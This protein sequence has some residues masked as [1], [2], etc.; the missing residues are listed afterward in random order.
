MFFWDHGGPA[1]GISPKA[2]PLLV[3]YEM[4]GGGFFGLSKAKLFGSKMILGEHFSKIWIPKN[5]GS[6]RSKI[7][8]HKIFSENV[9]K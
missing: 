2:N 1:P 5:F 4:G 9:D 6:S 3:K 7:Y 8:G